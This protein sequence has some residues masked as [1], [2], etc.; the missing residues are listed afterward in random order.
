MRLLYLNRHSQKKSLIFPGVRGYIFFIIMISYRSNGYIKEVEKKS[1]DNH[2][3][4]VK[5]KA[6]S[7]NKR[8]VW[9]YVSG[10]EQS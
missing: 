10:P 8:E 4:D 9:P 1:R 7:A 3:L 2:H 5:F 6:L